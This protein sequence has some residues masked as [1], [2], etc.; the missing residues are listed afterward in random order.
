KDLE[1][2]GL[3]D[4]VEVW[5]EKFDVDVE[6]KIN[7]LT[8]NGSLN[9]VTNIVAGSQPHNLYDDVKKDYKDDFSYLEKYINSMENG[10]RNT[11]QIASDGK[12]TIFRGYTEPPIDISK[13]NDLWFKELGSGEVEAYIFD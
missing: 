7:E 9:Q 10:I 2:I 6:V 3:T 1:H 12:S 4:T 13:L 11:I 8:Y 5:V